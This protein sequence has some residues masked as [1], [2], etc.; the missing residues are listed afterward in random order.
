M[1][2]HTQCRHKNGP[3]PGKVQVKSNSAHTSISEIQPQQQQQYNDRVF[4]NEIEALSAQFQALLKRR[5]SSNA[6]RK[7]RVQLPQ[8][9]RLR[10]GPRRPRRQ[11][12][13]LQC[14]QVLQKARLSAKSLQLLHQGLGAG[15]LRSGQDVHSRKR[16]GH[17]RGTGRIRSSNG[18]P[19][20][21]MATA[22]GPI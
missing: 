11:H 20:Q 2:A 17:Q 10:L 1:K 22:A 7:G 8:Q 12:N 13:R 18:T 4:D 14:V 15:G 21:P 9:S 19:K 3:F 5:N 6:Q 16:I